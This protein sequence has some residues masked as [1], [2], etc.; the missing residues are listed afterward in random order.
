MGG[1]VVPNFIC[2]LPSELLVTTGGMMVM[3]VQAPVYTCVLG[4]SLVPYHLGTIPM[5]CS[6]LKTRSGNWL[7]YLIVKPAFFNGMEVKAPN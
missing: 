4:V 3:A 1:G 5:F 2:M 6:H 7:V